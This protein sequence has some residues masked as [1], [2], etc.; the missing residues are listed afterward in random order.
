[1]TACK[2]CD[3]PVD[4]PH[5]AGCPALASPT[6]SADTP[7]GEL[8]DEFRAASIGE[9]RA[10]EFMQ[11][12]RVYDPSGSIIR[13]RAARQAIEEAFSKL[14]EERGALLEWKT[15]VM[16]ALESKPAFREARWA[17]DKRGWG[18]VF[19][20]VNW[21]HR[22]IE[23]LSALS[24]ENQR[25]RECRE[26]LMEAANV[27]SLEWLAEVERLQATALTPEEATLLTD[28]AKSFDAS[29][30]PEHPAAKSALKKL[31]SLS[32]PETP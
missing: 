30:S 25:L 14:R 10:I 26:G 28:C 21:L 11:G 16:G 17:G 19:E 20:Y 31:R 29:L 5:R 2:Y 8:L 4:E 1:M 24:L 15:S 3:E 12:S 23:G 27:N 13:Y 7:L 18:F 9:S 6:P 32:S 22:E